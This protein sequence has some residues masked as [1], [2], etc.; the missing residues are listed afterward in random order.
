MHQ[1]TLEVHW[2]ESSSAGRDT[3]ILGGLQVVHK[4]AI[5]LRQPSMFW[6]AKNI[7]VCT[8]ETHLECCVQFLSPQYRRDIDKLK[9]V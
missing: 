5:C 1:Y 9:Q 6:A 7:L 2:L 3:G 4:P 8:G